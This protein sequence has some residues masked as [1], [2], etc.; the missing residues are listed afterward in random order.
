MAGVLEFLRKMRGAEAVAGGAT[1]GDTMPGA[2]V[3]FR[4]VRFV[5]S[6][7][8]SYFILGSDLVAM[9]L[10]FVLAFWAAGITN[11]LVFGRLWLVS[12]NEVTIRIYDFTFLA[13]VMLGYLYQRGHYVR[14]MLFWTAMA[15]L[16]KVCIA[17]MLL[18]TFVQFLLK[19]TISRSWFVWIWLMLPPFLVGMRVAT[20]R[21]LDLVG[22]WQRR[23]L[24]AG[25]A[26]AARVAQA[27]LL[28]DPSMGY[29][30]A[31]RVPL[32][33]I[34]DAPAGVS[35]AAMLR[36]HGAGLLVCAPGD[37]P[38]QMPRAKVAALVREH[39]DFAV[40]PNLEGLPAAGYYTQ[41]FFRY[42]VVL[43]SYRNNADLPVARAAKLAFDVVAAGLLVLVLLPA[44]ALIALAIKRDGGPVF[45]AQRRIGKDGRMFGC[46][47]FRT[48]VMNGDQ[49][50]RKALAADPRLAMEWEATQKLRR[51]PRVTG[52]GHLLRLT[53]LD[54]LPQLLNVLRM[55]MSL[56]GPRPIIERE[57]P[58]YRDDFAWYCV[59]RPGLTGLWQVSGR[60]DTSYARKV[61]L[62]SWYVRNWSLWQDM[63]ILMKTIPAVLLRR[64]AM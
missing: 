12:P 20:R 24:I 64:G 56:V 26:E 63:V 51:D 33:D 23:V 43:L 53:S 21:V 46:L 1:M 11:E 47:K 30:I 6:T 22:L 55:D 28:S 16:L 54:E 50:L 10:A 29:E 40:M 31:G 52:I 9:M 14:R 15:D 45:Y 34:A 57:V 13:L 19:Q 2:T 37:E 27:A 36:R 3:P 17:G 60:S 38:F 61:H 18:D 7:A 62:D 44:I 35:F 4:P 25:D 58:R 32:E 8:W 49:V 59:V 41:F 48:M 39:V 5:Q 42:D